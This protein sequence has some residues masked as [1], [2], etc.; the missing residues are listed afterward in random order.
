MPL[1]ELGALLF[2]CEQRVEPFQGIPLPKRHIVQ[3]VPQTAQGDRRL[4][5]SAKRGTLRNEQVAVAR[6]D[7]VIVAKPQFGLETIP[8]R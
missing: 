2:R 6:N 7:N 4:A 8:E 1:H 5:A 3:P